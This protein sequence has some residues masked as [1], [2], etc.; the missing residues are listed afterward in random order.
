MTKLLSYWTTWSLSHWTPEPLSQWATEPLKHWATE[1]LSLLHHRATQHTTSCTPKVY[2]FTSPC[3]CGSLLDP[4]PCHSHVHS[5][6][7]PQFLMRAGIYEYHKVYVVILEIRY[8]VTIQHKFM[9]MND[10]LVRAQSSNHPSLPALPLSLSISLSLS[11]C[12]C[13]LRSRWHCHSHLDK[14][15]CHSPSRSHIHSRSFCLT[16]VLYVSLFLL[17]CISQGVSVCVWESEGESGDREMWCQGESGTDS[18]SHT[19]SISMKMT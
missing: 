4:I 6:C 10:I 5:H 1:P 13:P 16:V 15:T 9:K 14:T 19:E 17:T 8:F 18:K 3:Y 11:R 7:H 12:W 2:V